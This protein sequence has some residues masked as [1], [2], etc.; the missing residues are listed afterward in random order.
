MSPDTY[1]YQVAGQKFSVSLRAYQALVS[2]PNYRLYYTP[3]SKRL[4]ALESV[5]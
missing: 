3:R 2:G 5:Q 1:Y 4:V